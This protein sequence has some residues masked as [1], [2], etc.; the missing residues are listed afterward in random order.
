MLEEIRS[1]I[2][3]SFFLAHTDQEH[4]YLA[5]LFHGDYP[6]EDGY[7]DR[8]L[9]NSLGQDW[10]T[11]VEGKDCLANHDVAI[12]DDREGNKPVN[13]YKTKMD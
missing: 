4:A 13:H 11:H 5:Q 8:S 2:L 10:F 9:V 7:T 12:E 6:E 3:K 1:F